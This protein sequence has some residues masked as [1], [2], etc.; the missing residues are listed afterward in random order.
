M[1]REWSI[2]KLKSKYRDFPKDTEV[3][4]I[5][6]QEDKS[7]AEIGPWDDKGNPTAIDEIPHH[8]IA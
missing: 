1:L 2:F 3:L 6:C 8:F 4:L 7:V 5:D